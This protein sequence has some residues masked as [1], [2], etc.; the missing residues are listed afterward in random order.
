MAMW[1]VEH[2]HLSASDVR[3]SNGCG[4]LR[5]AVRMLT[6]SRGSKTE[7]SKWT[8]IVRWLVTTFDLNERDLDHPD[9]T[10]EELRVFARVL[11]P[12]A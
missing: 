9:T 5:A 3:A 2:F 10:A 6:V 4:P 7:S 1:L 12:D 8:R 11:T